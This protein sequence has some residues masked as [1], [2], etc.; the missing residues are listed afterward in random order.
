[1]SVA[2]T[3]TFLFKDRPD[4]PEYVMEKVLRTDDL[5]SLVLRD[6]YI[7]SG[8]TGKERVSRFTGIE[9]YDG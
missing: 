5:I 6:G 7:N 9:M 3:G 1:M 4:G 2:E 8:S